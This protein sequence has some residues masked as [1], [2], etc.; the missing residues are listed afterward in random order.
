MTEDEYRREA[1]ANC[2]KEFW[3][4]ECSAIANCTDGES[5]WGTINSILGDDKGT[6]Q[7]LNRLGYTGLKIYSDGGG[8]KFINYVIFN[9]KDITI[10]SVDKANGSATA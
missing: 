7:F 4:Y 9:P 3:E 5:V 1:Y 8:E 6:S 2:Q 10:L